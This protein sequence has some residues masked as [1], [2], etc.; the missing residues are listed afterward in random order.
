MDSS[1]QKLIPQ[2][3]EDIDQAVWLM[4]EDFL[5]TCSPIYKNIHDVLHMNHAMDMIISRIIPSVL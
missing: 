1:K 2:S 5:K 3:E 4:E